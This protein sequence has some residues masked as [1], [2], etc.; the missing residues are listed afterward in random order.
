MR[1]FA[2]QGFQTSYDSYEAMVQDGYD[3]GVPM[4][5]DYTG[6]T[7]P[8]ILVWAIKDPIGPGLDRIQ[9]IKG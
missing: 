6:D 7:A 2:G 5:R 1:A 9:I 8:Q 3:K 4:G